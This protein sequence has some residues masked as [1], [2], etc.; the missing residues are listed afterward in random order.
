MFENDHTKKNKYAR[1]LSK[2]DEIFENVH[3]EEQV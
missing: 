1:V 3:F 2:D